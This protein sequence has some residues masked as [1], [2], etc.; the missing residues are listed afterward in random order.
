MPSAGHLK[1]WREY[2]HH[3]T[4]KE[5]RERLEIMIIT[6]NLNP[7]LDKTVEIKNF[8]VGKLNRISAIRQDASGKGINVSKVIKSLGGTSKAIGLVGG[9]TGKFIKDCL[10]QMEIDNEFRFI[11]GETRTNIKI[12]DRARNTNTEVNE[13]GPS[14][15][16]HDIEEVERILVN[17]LDRNSIAV[18]SG[19]VPANADKDIYGRWIKLVRSYGAK[20]ILDADRDL[21]KYGIKEGPFLIKPNIHE[22]EELCGTKIN[23]P[24]EAERLGRS[25]LSEYGIELAVVSMGERGAVYISKHLSLLAHAVKVDAIS[26]IGAG[27]AMTAALA[28]SIDKGYDFEKALTLSMASGIANVMT[29][30]SQAADYSMIQELEGRITYEPIMRF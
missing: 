28:H 1:A 8:E 12:V 21:L 7:A 4:G 24:E 5:E 17:N 10:D 16:C 30:G 29:S 2:R 23:G 3:T 9:R 20:A 14:I 6:V 15:S 19:S 22:L 25:V 11:Q 18:F 27:D 13:P 26:T